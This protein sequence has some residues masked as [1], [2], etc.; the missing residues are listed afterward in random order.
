MEEKKPLQNSVFGTFKRNIT[1]K[2]FLLLV[3]G[4]MI[5]IVGWQTVVYF[6]ST[7]KIKEFYTSEIIGIITDTKKDYKG[8]NLVEVNNTWYNLSIYGACI[9]S[10]KV[11]DKI[12]KVANSFTIRIEPEDCAIKIIE[13]KCYS[14]RRFETGHTKHN[15][16]G[17]MQ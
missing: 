14:N 16:P 1:K 8:F 17:S 9:N 15:H 11:G 5:I 12:Q 6:F 2:N 10:I 3:L 13:Y 7:K 4:T